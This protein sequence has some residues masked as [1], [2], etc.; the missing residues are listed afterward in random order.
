MHDLLRQT[1]GPYED[2]DNPSG[3]TLAEFQ[4][5]YE[6]IVRAVISRYIP[7][8]LGDVDDLASEIWLQF[9]E[10]KEGVSYLKI[11][12]PAE[13][14]GTTFMWEFTR[15]RCLQY[16][17]RSTRTPTAYAYSIQNQEADTFTVGVVDPET[18]Y[19]LSVD[20]SHSIEFADIVGVNRGLHSALET[21]CLR[22]LLSV[23]RRH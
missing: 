7:R 16:L 13:S 10:G 9:M 4:S 21:R 12:N 1:K 19:E 18:T 8:S 20:D 6:H 5:K 3:M 11:Y 2:R 14:A 22:T 15:R 23:S 17:S